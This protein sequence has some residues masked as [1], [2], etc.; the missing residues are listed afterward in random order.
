MLDIS[1]RK[2]RL[3]APIQL[4]LG[5]SEGSDVEVRIT[6]RRRSLPTNAQ[7]NLSW[8]TVISGALA[9]SLTYPPRIRRGQFII[10]LRNSPASWVS[11]RHANLISAVAKQSKGKDQL[12]VAETL[13]LPNKTVVDRLKALVAAEILALHTR[14]P[15][16][17]TVR[18]PSKLSRVV[19]PDLGVILEQFSARLCLLLAFARQYAK[20]RPGGATPD[21][22]LT[23]WIGTAAAIAYY[24]IM[25]EEQEQPTPSADLGVILEEL[26]RLEGYQSLQPGQDRRRGLV[27]YIVVRALQGAN[28]L[29]R[30]S[31]IAPLLR[32]KP[33]FEN[34]ESFHFTF[35]QPYTKKLKPYLPFFT[36]ALRP[37]LLGNPGALA[38]ELGLRPKRAF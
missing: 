3:D 26:S 12:T 14:L 20:H 15:V 34:I 16:R 1:F 19:P 25:R 37:H 29:R 23:F 30:L 11:D 31:T 7:T 28:D 36:E 6:L 4:K 13:P 24:I 17:L 35:V 9:W 10:S 18:F 2:N 21:L 22:P 32:N 33:D 5:L 38:Q 27:A 8:A